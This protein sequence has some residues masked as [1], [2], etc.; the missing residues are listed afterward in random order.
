MYREEMGFRVAVATLAMLTVLLT[1]V[2]TVTPVSGVQT[3][4]PNLIQSG[5]TDT[6]HE[7][8][9]RLMLRE[10]FEIAGIVLAALSVAVTAMAILERKKDFD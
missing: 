4:D 2:L 7:Y 1:F 5:D 9:I 10:L 3:D 8:S 6:E